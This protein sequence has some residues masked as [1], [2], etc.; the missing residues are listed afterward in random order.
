MP[1]PHCSP[2]SL[3][4]PPQNARGI[5]TGE[6]AGSALPGPA[7]Q[8]MERRARSSSRESHGKG[9]GSPRTENKRAKGERSGGGRGRR[10]AGREQPDLRRAG[11]PG[12]ARAAAATVVDVDE[13]RGSGEE[14]TEVVALLE[15]ERPEEGTAGRVETLEGGRAFHVVPKGWQIKW[16][17]LV[18]LRPEHP[19]GAT[20]MANQNASEE[21][22]I[23]STGAS[24]GWEVGGSVV[25]AGDQPT[26][27]RNRAAVF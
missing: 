22:Q 4:S 3:W 25:Q 11:R 19:A 15:S 20:Q 13:V 14:G 21:I 18:S 16:D 2:R 24:C 9:G 17:D 10:G 27:Q 12:E 5:P 8:R 6:R 26:W 23:I 1:R 7:A